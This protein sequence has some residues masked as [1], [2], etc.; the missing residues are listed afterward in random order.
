[1][2]AVHKDTDQKI[3]GAI[4]Y[5]LNAKL[6]I[7]KRGQKSE[8][9]PLLLCKVSFE[10]HKYFLFY[11]FLLSYHIHWINMYQYIRTFLLLYM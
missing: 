9:T 5:I 11:N 7:G 10:H 6:Q 2:I 8:L 3:D 1:M 4:V